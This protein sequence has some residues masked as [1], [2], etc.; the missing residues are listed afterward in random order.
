MNNKTFACVVMTLLPLPCFIFPMW[1]WSTMHRD[2]NQRFGSHNHACSAKG[3]RTLKSIVPSTDVWPF[4]LSSS[5]SASKNEKAITSGSC[6]GP[7][8]PRLRSSS[9]G[10]IYTRR[11]VGVHGNTSSHVL[12]NPKSGALK[13]ALINRGDSSGHVWML[14]LMQLP[15]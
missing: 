13:E 11:V 6:R 15:H 8:K 1:L 9:D 5:D 14:F 12:L 2:Y 3:T 7:A 4:S 10:S